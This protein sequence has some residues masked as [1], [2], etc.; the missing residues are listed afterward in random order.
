MPQ[1]WV[2]FFATSQIGEQPYFRILLGILFLV[3]LVKVVIKVAK[4]TKMDDLKDIPA[5][6]L[7]SAGVLCFLWF[8]L[9]KV[10][11]LD[12]LYEPGAPPPLTFIGYYLR[13]ILLFIR[14]VELYLTGYPVI[15]ANLPEDLLKN[16]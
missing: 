7:Y 3:I 4:H 1:G 6:M 12:R 11:T 15:H 10:V 5:W 9:C 13:A 2:D 16:L 14:D 8:L